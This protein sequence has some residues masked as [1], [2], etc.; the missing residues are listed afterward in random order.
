MKSV[1]VLTGASRGI[2]SA[3]A[4]DLAARYSVI[5]LG[6]RDRAGLEETARNVRAANGKPV[7]VAVDVRTE[8]GRNALIAA[9]EAEG[10]I[11]VLINNAGIEVA[12]PV[13]EQ[14]AAEIEAQLDVN[15]RAPILL[16]RGVLP[17]MVKRG[18][19]SIVMVSSMSGKS[20]TPYNSVYSASKFGLNGFAGSLQFELRGTGVNV[21]VVCPGFVSGK[22]MWADTNVKAPLLMREVSIG[23]VVD[24]VRKVIS[25]KPEVLVTPGPVRP[26]LALSQM[27]PTWI[28]VLLR[29]MGITNVLEERSRVVRRK[30]SLSA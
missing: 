5:V 28:P 22:G 26:L 30:R 25:G 19:G 11:E 23:K 3:I 10:D 2:G 1:A 6:A 24:G 9:A 29:W 15:L 18:R 8:E 12:V 13:M 4:Q 20:P 17:G 21:G 14:S 7:L 27:R 16:T